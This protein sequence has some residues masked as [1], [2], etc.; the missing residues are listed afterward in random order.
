MTLIHK[1]NLPDTE[2]TTFHSGLTASPLPSLHPPPL[3]PKDPIPLIQVLGGITVSFAS[4]PPETD[5]EEGG[6]LKS[7]TYPH[8]PI[9]SIAPANVGLSLR[10]LLSGE[11]SPP[12]SGPEF[13]VSGKAFLCL[14]FYLA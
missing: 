9:S 2:N 5:D 1:P 4:P 13:L 12:L 11:E 6:G 10:M 3:S 14:L 8:V 7:R